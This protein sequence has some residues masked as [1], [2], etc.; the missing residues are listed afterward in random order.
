MI[1]I[2]I[3]CVTMNFYIWRFT[4]YNKIF[5]M[6][7]QSESKKKKEEL[8]ITKYSYYQTFRA[9]VRNTLTSKNNITYYT[10]ISKSTIYYVFSITQEAKLPNNIGFGVSYY[11]IWVCNNTYISPLFNYPNVA[12]PIFQWFFLLNTFLPHVV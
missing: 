11:S 6:I 1:K 5:K 10:P 4:Y 9:Y 2:I 8:I 7:T 12:L 3:K